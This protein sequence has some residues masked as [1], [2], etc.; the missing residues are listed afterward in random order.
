V[1]VVAAKFM[2]EAAEAEAGGMAVVAAAKAGAVV[3]VTVAVV[4]A[5]AANV[6][7]NNPQNAQNGWS[8]VKRRISDSRGIK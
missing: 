3:A 5:A 4:V 6:E 7:T 2:G 1:D 8:R